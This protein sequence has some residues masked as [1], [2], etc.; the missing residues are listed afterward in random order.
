[1]LGAASD[2]HI[3]AR[4]L[5][6]MTGETVLEH[7]TLVMRDGRIL[8]ILPHAAAAERYTPRVLLERPSHLLMPGLVNA[9]TSCLAGAASSF[10][11]EPEVALASIANL[12]HA[13]TTCVCDV[14]YFPNEV[15]RLATAQGLRAVIGLPVAERPSAWAQDARGYLSRG[16]RLRDEYKGHPSISAL[17][18][19]LQ[20]AE[21]G[22]AVLERLSTL[23]NELDA[24]VMIALHES[25]ADVGES[26]RR[27]GVPPIPRLERLGLLTPA[28][29]ATHALALGPED[30]ELAQRTGIGVTLCLS[31]GLLRGAGLPPFAALRSLRMSLGSDAAGPGAGQDLWTEIKLYALHSGAGPQ[32]ALAAATRGGAGILGLDAEIG[33]LERGKWAD[34]CCVDLGGPATQPLVDPLRQLVYSGGRDLVSDVWVAGRQLLSEGQ[35]TRLDWPDVAQRLRC[36]AQR[37][38]TGES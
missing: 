11:F 32:A 3:K 20:P 22:D 5:V 31:S 8:D 37:A 24:G 6:P 1:M 36:A 23:V 19:P 4:W 27:H 13:G 30:L 7:H 9:R 14:G 35:F 18:A 29:T 34:V 25:E 16:L 15:A 17:F 2:T 38:P 26:I 21:I 33:S 28:L 10:E 12:I